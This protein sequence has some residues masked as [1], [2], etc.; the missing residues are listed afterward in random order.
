[1]IDQQLFNNIGKQINAVIP[2]EVKAVCA[3]LDK[4]IKSVV[5]GALAKVDMVPR[6][7]FDAQCKVLARTRS[8]LEQLEQKIAQLEQQLLNK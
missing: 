7:E 4:N 8:K 1:M 5:Q 6:E 2:D 3:D